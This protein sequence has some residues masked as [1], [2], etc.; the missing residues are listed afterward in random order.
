MRVVG[1]DPGTKSFDLCGLDGE[2]VM[3]DRT[4]PSEELNKKPS[5]FVEALEEVA[6]L[7]L[8]VGHSGLGIELM[9]SRE[10]G[11]FEIGQMLFAPRSELQGE[12]EGGTP[13][14]IKAMYKLYRELQ[15]PETEFRIVYVPAVVHLPTVPKHRKINKIDMGT[16]DKLC[17]A[18]LGV[19][20]Q[21]GRLG[22]AYDE[23]SFILVEAGF[24]F[25]AVL[26]VKEGQ[27][28]DGSGGTLGSPGFLA[29]GSIDAELSRVIPHL[30]P[31]T[32]LTRGSFTTGGA[33]SVSG[34]Q[35]TPRELPD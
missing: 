35:I 20:E 34:E 11:D 24:G 28:V 22:I 3:L 4:L 16:S 25:T 10:V 2:T 33:L 9:G 19:K 1:V 6:P 8:V 31:R 32:Q 21:S 13:E 26:A 17:C 18:L 15:K 23:T 14:L 27:V 7:D 5:L 30:I 12:M 29:P